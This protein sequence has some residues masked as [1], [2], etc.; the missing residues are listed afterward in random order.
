MNVYETKTSHEVGKI[1]AS[2][3]QTSNKQT[4]GNLMDMIEKESQYNNSTYKNQDHQSLTIPENPMR[5][6]S[7]VVETYVVGKGNMTLKKD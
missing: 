7:S 5:W 3:K 2:N 1:S 4:Y 6:T